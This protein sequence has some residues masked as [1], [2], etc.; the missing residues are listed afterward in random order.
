[1]KQE[2]SSSIESIRNAIINYVITNQPSS[3]NTETIPLDQSLL[4]LEVLDSYGVVELVVFLE[5]NW[6]IKIDD[7]EITKEK[8]GSINKMAKLIFEKLRLKES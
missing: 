4:E 3:Y 7:S 8:M 2:R 5:N 6:S 1:M